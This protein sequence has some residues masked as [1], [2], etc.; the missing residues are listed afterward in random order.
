MKS[1][2]LV[3]VSLALLFTT[4]LAVADDKAAKPAKAEPAKVAPA[5]PA[6]MPMGPPKPAPE[7][8]ATYKVLEGSW[9]CDTTFAADSMGPGSPEVKVKTNIKFKKDLTGFWYRGDFEAKKSKDFPGMKGTIYLGMMA[10][11]CSP[12]TWTRWAGSAPVPASPRATR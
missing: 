7:L 11:N 10:S 5:P 2:R 1:P 12:S 8:D 6:G 3:G 4:S 9:K